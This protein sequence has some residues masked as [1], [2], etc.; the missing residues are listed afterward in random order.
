MSIHSPAKSQRLATNDG[1]PYSDIVTYYI[2]LQQY[3]LYRGYDSRQV[4]SAMETLD[5]PISAKTTIN[6]LMEDFERYAVHSAIK[7]LQDKRNSN[8]AYTER[9]NVT[10]KF[11][12]V[13]ATWKDHL[14]IGIRGM[15]SEINRDWRKH[16][17]ADLLP[18]WL[19]RLIGRWAK[20]QYRKLEFIQT[21]N[22]GIYYCWKDEVRICPHMQYDVNKNWAKHGDFMT[23]HSVSL[24]PWN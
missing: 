21:M 2:P 23:F 16:Y 24:K 5:I 10:T 17:A 8:T 7:L 12:S 20:P 11:F 13:P 19:R 9:S 22:T 18:T 1:L 4:Q 14:K 15:V 6:W 3:E